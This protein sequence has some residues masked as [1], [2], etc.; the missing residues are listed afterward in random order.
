LYKKKQEKRKKQ[1]KEYLLIIF[2]LN[3]TL[4]IFI[5]GIKNKENHVV[6]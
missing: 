2:A 6:I 4:L 5:Y 1:E 3:V